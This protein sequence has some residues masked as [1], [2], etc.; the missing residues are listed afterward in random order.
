VRNPE[1]RITYTPHL[2][3]SPA[4]DR[5]LP[6]GLVEGI[7][8][9]PF[10]NVQ[11]GAAPGGPTEPAAPA[12]NVHVELTDALASMD[13]EDVDRYLISKK[14]IPEGGTFLDLSETQARWVIEHMESFKAQVEK[15]SD[16]PF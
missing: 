15:F 13:L 7:I 12:I 16:Q 6:G 1:R 8:I 3:P 14:R 4:S 11:T 9:P 10:L 5:P 2:L